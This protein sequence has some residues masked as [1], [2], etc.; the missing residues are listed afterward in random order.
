VNDGSSDDTAQN[1][2]GNT[3]SRIRRFLLV[4]NPGKPRQRVTVWRNGMAACGAGRH[5]PVHGCRSF[6]TD[7]GGAR[8]TVR[9]NWSRR[10]PIAIGGRDGLRAELQ[11]ERQPLLPPGVWTNL[12]PGAAGDSGLAFSPTHN[13]DSKPF[14]GG[15]RAAHLSAAEK[16]SAGDSIRKFCFWR[17][18]RACGWEEGPSS[19]GRTVRGRRLCTLSGTDCECS[20][21]VLRIRWYAMTG[22]YAAGAVPS[23]GKL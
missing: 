16:L 3:A 2:A 20:W 18:A 6:F 13:A 5:L 4:E 12:Q 21:K 10:R 9:R 14:G 23:P 7:I 19:V 22:E 15:R 1:R 8:E 17:G 11:T